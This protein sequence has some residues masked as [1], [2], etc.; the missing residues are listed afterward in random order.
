M[1]LMIV[2]VAMAVAASPALGQDIRAAAEMEG[3]IKLIET[4]Y[5][6]EDQITLGVA[7]RSAQRLAIM[8]FPGQDKTREILQLERDLEDGKISIDAPDDCKR[9]IDD[10][11]LE[12]YPF[13]H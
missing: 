4:A 2:G 6:C 11:K 5:V 12:A 10:A 7:I 3:H 13:G 1:R 8:S 9:A